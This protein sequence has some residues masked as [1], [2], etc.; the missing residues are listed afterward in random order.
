MSI[1]GNTV[2][3]ADNSGIHLNGRTNVESNVVGYCGNRGI[4]LEIEARS[5]VRGNTVFKNGGPG[6]EIRNLDTGSVENNISF[7]NNGWGLVVPAAAPVVLRCNDWFQNQ[8]GAVNGTSPGST[9][10]NVDPMFCNVD[11]SDVRLASTS[12]LID[13]AGCGQIGAL[14]LGCG[15]T[16]T[17]FEG[18]AVD[19]HVLGAIVRW[20]FGSARPTDVWVE[21]SSQERGPWQRVNRQ[22]WLLEETYE[23][24]D[25]DVQPGRTY[26]YRVSCSGE[27]GVSYSWPV[28]F[29]HEELIGATRLSPNPALGPVT[30]EWTLAAAAEVQIGVYDLAGRQVASLARGRFDAGSHRVSWNR[31]QSNG[32]HAPAGYYLVRVRGGGIASTHQLLLLR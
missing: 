6:L 10:L 29:T 15:V 19:A 18:F 8:L 3:R 22:P 14:G 9:D 4:S 1:T 21:R 31:R 16:A 24:V 7:G 13:P 27:R 28:S 5:R 20:R 26:W 12:P 11:S 32:T 17:L 25:E 2:L 30:L 23:L